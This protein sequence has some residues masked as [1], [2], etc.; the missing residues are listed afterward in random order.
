MFTV[1]S[2]KTRQKRRPSLSRVVSLAEML[3]TAAQRG[4]KP[5][6]RKWLQ[7]SYDDINTCVGKFEW[8]LQFFQ[9][10]LFNAVKI[11]T[12]S[13]SNG[14]MK[15]LQM[16]KVNLR[17]VFQKCCMRDLHSVDQRLDGRDV[18]PQ[19]SMEDAGPGCYSNRKFN[20]SRLPVSEQ[21]TMNKLL[22]LEPKVDFCVA[23]TNPVKRKITPEPTACF[24]LATTCLLHITERQS[25]AK[26][27]RA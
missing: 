27:L 1:D 19:V 9:S 12:V 26:H 17:D 20:W 6:Q 23:W 13:F 8:E 3:I 14:V 10:V 2:E 25:Q 5:Q 11:T 7:R 15:R 24:C 16:Q 21:Q 18:W 22:S 4:L